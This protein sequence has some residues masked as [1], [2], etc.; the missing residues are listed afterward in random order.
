MST[1]TIETFQL[2]LNK[3]KEDKKPD[4]VKLP[5]EEIKI[6]GIQEEIEKIPN[7]IPKMTSQD[8]KKEDPSW[9]IPT[10][11]SPEPKSAVKPELKSE[12][13]IKKIEDNIDPSQI[14]QNRISDMTSSLS[15]KA[16]ISSY[17]QDYMSANK[18][19][20]EVSKR[21]KSILSGWLIWVGTFIVLVG[22]VLMFTEGFIKIPKF[23]LSFVKK[24]PK[25]VLL[26]STNNLS[27]LKSY[28][29]GT[30]VSISFPSFSNITSSLMEGENLS[31]QDKDSFSFKADGIVDKKNSTSI[32]FDYD[33]V[34]NSSIIEDEIKTNFKYDGRSS[35]VNVPDLSKSLGE[36]SP[37]VGLVSIPNEQLDEINL[38]LPASIQEKVGKIELS[39]LLPNSFSDITGSYFS[40]LFKNFIGGVEMIKKGEQDIGGILTYNYSLSV[41]RVFLKKF[42]SDILNVVL[43]NLSN[44]EKLGMDQILGSA[45][46]DS[47]EVWIGKKDGNL[48]KYKFKLAVPL[49]KVIGLD[50]KTMANNSVVL[51]WETKYFDLDLPNSVTIPVQTIGMDDFVNNINDT[52]IKN[53]ISSFSVSANVMKNALGNYGKKS[54]S[55]G[56]CVEPTSGSLFSP[57]GHTKGASTVVGTIASIMNEITSQ[58]QGVS[59]CYST[60]KNWAIASPLI[61]DPD[62]YFCSDSEGN[63][64]ILNESLTGTVCPEIITEQE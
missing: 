40:L 3:P 29:V 61:S 30:K 9:D 33:I 21:K 6:E 7:L 16:M 48:Y 19:K 43:P 15:K 32:F 62:S 57:L 28:K 14:K 42:L 5:V 22:I 39:K 25:I 58:T 18:L 35:F 64:V 41:D 20:E 47:F 53:L 54:N 8:V 10:Q 34:L 1:R 37:L 55:K 13:V 51:D 52:K 46:V 31:F 50:D 38:F 12:P 24:D 27:L 4:P 59:A 45:S 11:Q 56:S 2:E 49:S 23:D 63:S 60:S 26:N 44:E 17:S 36:K